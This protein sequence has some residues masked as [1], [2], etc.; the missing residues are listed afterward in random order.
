[1]AQRVDGNRLGFLA[2]SF[3]LVC[4]V[5]LFASYATPIPYARGM[6][7]EQALDDALAT[8]NAADPKAALEAMRD[9]LGDQ[10]HIVLGDTGSLAERVAIA[11]REVGAR[12]TAEGQ[13]TATNLRILVVVTSVICALFG[14]ALSGVGIRRE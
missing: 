9:R 4:L 7:R 11:R 8:A 12:V 6:L 5:G 10:A 14:I 13:E 3:L 1:M 2:V